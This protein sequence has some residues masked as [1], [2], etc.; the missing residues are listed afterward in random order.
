MVKPSQRIA[1]ER[2]RFNSMI[3][4]MCGGDMVQYK[5]VVSSEVRA[6]LIKYENYTNEIR[7]LKKEADRMKGVHKAKTTSWGK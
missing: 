7:Q 4:D 3:M 5:V 2:E 6:F 1:A